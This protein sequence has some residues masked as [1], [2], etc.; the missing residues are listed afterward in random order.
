MGEV[1]LLQGTVKWSYD[2]EMAA[3]TDN[4]K[5][6]ASM[7]SFTPPLHHHKGNIALSNSEL[8]I[9]GIGDD[10]DLTINLGSLKQVYLGFDVLYPALSVRS[11]GVFW[12]PLR[13][14]YYTSAVETQSVYLIIDFNGIYIELHRY[15]HSQ[16]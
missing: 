8:I 1:F 5:L 15:G 9:E 4:Q 12:Q 13:V 6:L 7:V 16:K 10:E 3:V 2:Y 14:E 11:L